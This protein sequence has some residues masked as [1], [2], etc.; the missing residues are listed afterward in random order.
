MKFR[1]Q[2]KRKPWLSGQNRQLFAFGKLGTTILKMFATY[3]GG[4]EKDRY[5]HAK[6]EVIRAD[7]R[8]KAER[9]SLTVAQNQRVELLNAK[10]RL[11]L[12]A[13]YGAEKVAALLGE[14]P[15]KSGEFDDIPH[16]V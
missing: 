11:E 14:T 15:A 5:Y 4:A 12:E 10:M 2:R 3:G 6:I 8:L 9:E 16:T 7:A 1:I 13:K